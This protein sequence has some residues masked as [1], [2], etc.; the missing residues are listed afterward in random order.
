MYSAV[1]YITL[2]EIKMANKL[3]SWY[4]KKVS[5]QST[6]EPLYF[7]TTLLTDYFLIS[8]SLMT[9]MAKNCQQLLTIF[10]FALYTLHYIIVHYSTVQYSTVQYSTV[11]YS[12]VQ[13]STVQY[14]TVQYST[15][16]YSTVQ[17]ST[18][19]YSTVQ[20]SI[21]QYSTVQCSREQ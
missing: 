5:Q 12:T 19:Q 6:L 18:V 13:Y 20:Y 16:Q 8:D 9:K 21:V 15:V 3:I 11:Q 10:Y 1:H 7:P 4:Y 2:I 14:S 17:Y